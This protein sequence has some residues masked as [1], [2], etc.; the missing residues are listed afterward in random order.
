[1]NKPY[2]KICSSV[3][4][5][6]RICIHKKMKLNRSLLALRLL[7]TLHRIRKS[8]QMSHL[9]KKIAK[10]DN[11]KKIAKMK[12]KQTPQEQKIKIP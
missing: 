11:L 6:S 1:M 5:K 8:P 3:I 12:V 4:A 7:S 10:S 2:N 9:Q